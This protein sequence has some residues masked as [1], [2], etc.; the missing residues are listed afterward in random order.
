MSDLIVECTLRPV[1]NRTSRP[2]LT[3]RLEQLNNP[4]NHTLFNEDIT[5]VLALSPA[6]QA[7][8]G[9]PAYRTYLKNSSYVRQAVDAL[10]Y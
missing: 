5:I 2:A 8:G 4:K 9:D 6:T 1:R 3:I 7:V 10:S